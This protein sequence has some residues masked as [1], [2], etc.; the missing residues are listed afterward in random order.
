MRLQSCRDV[1]RAAVLPALVGMATSAFAQ[2]MYSVPGS[3]Y[4]GQYEAQYGL[5]RH[6]MGHLRDTAS[7][8]RMDR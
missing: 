8:S 3:G 5:L 4:G 7:H 6:N 1:L 2:P